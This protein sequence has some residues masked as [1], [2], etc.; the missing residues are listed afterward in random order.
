MTLAALVAARALTPRLPR[1]VPPG[2]AP[3]DVVLHVL[4][5]AGA[6]VAIGLQEVRFQES[7]AAA[8]EIEMDK[9]FNTVLAAPDPS[10]A[11]ARLRRRKARSPAPATVAMLTTVAA[12]AP[13]A[14]GFAGLFTMTP[15]ESRRARV[16]RLHDRT[17]WVFARCRQMVD[18]MTDSQIEA[19]VR[20]HEETLPPLAV[21]R[22]RSKL[23]G[24]M[25]HGKPIAV[26]LAQAW[27]D[28]CNRRLPDVEHWIE[29]EGS[30]R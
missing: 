8:E 16:Q 10:E 26:D 11:L 29:T 13:L 14:P 1:E 23:T 30:K 25:G 21:V 2:A 22:W 3:Y 18:T 20:E 4:D 9:S 6:A 7:G 27:A 28:D 12:L 24:A 17:G 5:V 19:A 15:G